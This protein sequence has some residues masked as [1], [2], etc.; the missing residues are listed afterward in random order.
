MGAESVVLSLGSRGAVGAF[1]DGVIEALPP[2]IDAVCPIGAGDALSAAY[3][4]S[5]TKKPN[6]A[7]AL[8]WGVA[9]GTASARLAGM[10]FANLE[11]TK[12]VYSQVEMRRAE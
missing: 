9:A 1:A 7:E 12:E 6:P 3:T 5:M 8:R 4:W 2:R 11:Q 10:R